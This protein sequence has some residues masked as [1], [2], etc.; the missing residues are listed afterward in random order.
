MAEKKESK[1]SEHGL[2]AYAVKKIAKEIG[3]RISKDA[4]EMYQGLPSKE[5]AKDML[6]HA[7]ALVHANKK[8]TIKPSLAKVEMTHYRQGKELPEKK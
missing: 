8:K 3:V 2:S 6:T 5:A 4:V 1:T 7:A